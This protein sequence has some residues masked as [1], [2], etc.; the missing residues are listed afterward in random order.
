MFG[1]LADMKMSKEEKADYSQ[2]SPPE[3]PWG[4][5]ISLGN[6]ELEKLGVD[7]DDEVCVGDMVHINAMA[8]VTSHSLNEN[9]DGPKRRVELQIVFMALEDE[10]EEVKKPTKTSKFYTK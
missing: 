4:L 3:Y 2:P 1:K 7:L 9:E 6:D 10:D 8:K 5:S